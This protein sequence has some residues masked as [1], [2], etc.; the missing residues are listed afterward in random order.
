M[1]LARQFSP[2]KKGKEETTTS[3]KSTEPF[4]KHTCDLFFH[5]G[6]LTKT[7]SDSK[8]EAAV[9]KK[10]TWRPPKN[11][12]ELV[13]IVL[14]WTQKEGWGTTQKDLELYYNTNPEGFK[15]LFDEN[16]T[17]VIGVFHVAH[18]GKKE[19]HFS[20]FF[21]CFIISE[22]YRGKGIGTTALAEIRQQLAKMNIGLYAVPSQ[23]DFYSK[24]FGFKETHKVQQWS[25]TRASHP[26]TQS[27]EVKESK[28][29]RVRAFN[30]E[31]L[32]AVTRY[33]QRFF[34]ARDNL[35]KNVAAM[36]SGFVITNDK[37]EIAGY[38]FVSTTQENNP[39]QKN[40]HH[41][42]GPVCASSFPDAQQ[43]IGTLLQNRNGRIV[44]NI[45]TLN[46]YLRPFVDYF[47]LTLEENFEVTAMYTDGLPPEVK[48]G[49][50]SIYS[51]AGLE[52]G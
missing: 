39:T 6:A 20:H 44:F 50:N 12:E 21:G 42:V 19:T 25:L 24:K 7:K 41:R 8:E 49:S 9:V 40:T 16:A 32:P 28:E 48:E 38:A 27:Q 46:E 10:F 35:L 22:A 23:A 26:E 13:K 31:M 2:S 51:T 47:G 5:D 37:G 11:F 14:P 15:L 29:T 3:T 1:T 4:L 43:L 36:A 52:I 18:Y 17:T 33:D 30:S 45:P 34:P